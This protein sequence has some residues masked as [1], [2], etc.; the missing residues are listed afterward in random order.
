MESGGWGYTVHTVIS[1]QLVYKPFQLMAGLFLGLPP[2]N[3]VLL[4]VG[5]I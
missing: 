1:D 3:P 4:W 5:L 2:A